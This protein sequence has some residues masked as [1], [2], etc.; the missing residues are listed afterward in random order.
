MHLVHVGLRQFQIDADG[1]EGGVAEHGLERVHVAAVAQ[2]LDR[3]GV[4]EAVRVVMRARS[5]WDRRASSAHWRMISCS[6]NLSAVIVIMLAFS[7]L[8]RVN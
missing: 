4:A 8:T 6:N 5:A 2:V 7:L 3:E 1:F